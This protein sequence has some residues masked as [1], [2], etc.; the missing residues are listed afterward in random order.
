MYICRC[1]C[2]LCHLASIN[3][4]NKKHFPLQLPLRVNIIQKYK[5]KAPQTETALRV[6]LYISTTWQ[7]LPRVGYFWFCLSGQCSGKRSISRFTTGQHCLLSDSLSVIGFTLY[8]ASEIE[9][10]TDTHTYTH[11]QN[12]KFRSW[13]HWRQHRHIDPTHMHIHCILQ[14]TVQTGLLIK[15]TPLLLYL[16][17]FRPQLHTHAHTIHIQYTHIQYDTKATFKFCTYSEER[18][19]LHSLDT[20]TRTCM[21]S[22]RRTHT[23][24]ASRLSKHRG[25]RN[26]HRLPLL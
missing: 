10:Y 6:K 7:V 17:I 13:L 14:T 19:D 15:S 4:C 3:E 1:H 23:L 9:P 11:A 21:S 20:Y 8:Q 12:L 24:R 16:L 22:P 18:A 5:T 25:E 2:C 26:E